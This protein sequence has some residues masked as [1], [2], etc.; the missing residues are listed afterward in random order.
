MDG[1]TVPA[2]QLPDENGLPATVIGQPSTFNL[3]LLTLI[4]QIGATYLV[5]EA[6]DG[7]YLVDQ[8]AAHE[9]VLYERALTARASGVP[10]T[11]PLL[12]AVVAPLSATQAALA[13]EHADALTALGFALDATDGP[14]VL[15][16]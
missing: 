10:E 8:H 2:H 12:S 16:R 15:R 6:P 4:G 1:D 14:A 11:Q 13:A 7:L 9:R 5:A 3:P